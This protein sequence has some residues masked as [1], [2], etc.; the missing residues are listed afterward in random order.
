MDFP[1]VITVGRQLG[2]GGRKIGKRLAERFGIAYYDKEILSLAA[3]ESGLGTGVFERSD[4]RKG[5]LRSIVQVVQPFFGGGG[6]FYDNQLSDENLFTI[7]SH[8][9]QKVAAERSC[10]VIGRVADYILR[11]HPHHINVFITASMSDRVQELMRRRG[12]DAKAAR[13][14]LEEADEERSTYYNFYSLGTWGTADTYDLC[15]NSSILGPDG[16]TDFIARF[17]SERFGL[18]KPEGN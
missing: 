2:S 9:I 5:F 10:V 11:H 8:V 7:Q 1:F 17:V 3:Q 16:T 12:I 18:N 14:I 13:R 6:N 4:E 15:I